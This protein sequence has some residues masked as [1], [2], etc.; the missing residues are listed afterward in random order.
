MQTFQVATSA[1][2]VLHIRTD[3]YVDVVY[4]SGLAPPHPAARDD[5]S[6][7][8]LCGELQASGHIHI[9]EL[10]C[11]CTREAFGYLRMAT[12]ERKR[13]EERRRLAKVG[14]GE[15]A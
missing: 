6:S 2:D 3:V 12:R 7:L 15:I 4:T 13:V 9:V 5:V 1:Y 14:E 10:R 11:E 8:A